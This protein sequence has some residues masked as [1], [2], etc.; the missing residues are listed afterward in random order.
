[1]AKRGLQAW[2]KMFGWKRRAEARATLRHVA[3]YL[4]AGA[5]VLDIGCGTGYL[6]EVIARDFRCDIYG[7]DVVRPPVPIEHFTLFDGFRLPYADKSVD[8]AILVFVLH[9]AEDPGV[10]LHEAARVAR[11]NVIVIEDTPRMALEHRWGRI[12]IH[13][14]GKRHNIPWHG[15]V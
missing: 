1:M 8:V 14:L 7:C 13:S 3:D 9:H 12:H 2:D 15:R 11:Q 4:P 10:L 5:R 6:L